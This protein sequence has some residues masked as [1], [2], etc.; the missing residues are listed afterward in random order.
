MKKLLLLLLFLCVSFLDAQDKYTPFITKQ[1]EYIYAINESN[2]T[3]DEIESILALQKKSYAD[4]LDSVMG[5][6]KAFIS[7][8]NLYDNKIFA[9]EKIIKINKR[10]G[11][12]FAVLRDEVQ[13][14]SYKLLKNQNSMLRNVLSSLSYADSSSFG[15]EINK[16]VAKNHAENELLL[17]VDYKSKLDL[18]TGSKT[19]KQLKSNIKEFYAL[20][21]INSDFIKYTYLFEDK[22]YSLNK[23]SKYHLINTVIFIKNTA[24]SNT[25]DP[26]LEPYG[27][28][29]VKIFIALVLIVLIYIIRKFL[30]AYIEKTIVNIESLKKYS[31]EILNVLRKPINVLII[32]I[33]VNMIIYVYNDFKSVEILTKFFNI[34]YVLILTFIIYK[35]LNTVSSIKINELDLTNT[36]IKMKL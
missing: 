10:A 12:S 20:I 21:D 19:L 22:I 6:K 36:K 24:I 32:V 23:Y 15:E 31:K 14:K 17:D 29:V 35:V 5:N 34:V 13:V 30:Y 18:E 26:I 27:L 7:K 2:I 1:L 33:N 9:L 11:N 25:L 3:H 4:S 16:Y 8:S 28:D